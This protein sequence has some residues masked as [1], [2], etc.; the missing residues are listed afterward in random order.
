[1]AQRLVPGEPGGL[2][3][4][5]YHLVGAQ[6]DCAVDLPSVTF[7]RQLQ[8]LK[9]HRR[10]VLLD[11]AMKALASG[12]PIREGMVAVTFDDAY[13]N[14]YEVAWP[15]LLELG[16]PA[17]LFVPVGF[18][19][20][21]RPAPIQGNV[22]GPPLRW[23]Q[24]REMLGSGNLEIGSHSWSHSD[25]RRLTPQERL[26]DLRQARETLEDRCGVAAKSFCYPKSLW[27]AQ[28]EAA[29]G[30][31]HSTAVIG[32]GWVLKPQNFQPLRLWRVSIRRDMPQR[33]G[34]LLNSKICLEEYLADGVRRMLRRNHGR[35][36]HQGP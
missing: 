3:I 36:R 26:E 5:A 25:F 17:T 9:V 35:R 13:G 16:V 21:K 20:G 22:G 10:A 12:S 30:K 19:E 23:N 15:I 4:L 24:I 29:V 2:L 34:R 32:G 11:D 14:F 1:M 6:A 8:E 31:I 33:L 7:R 28:C 18:L 27:S